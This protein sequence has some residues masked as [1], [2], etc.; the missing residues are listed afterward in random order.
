[1]QQIKLQWQSRLK[2]GVQSLS[3]S[4]QVLHWKVHFLVKNQIPHTTVFPDLIELLVANG[5]TL[6]EKHL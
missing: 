3:Y 6:L 1:M 5:D 4:V 2:V